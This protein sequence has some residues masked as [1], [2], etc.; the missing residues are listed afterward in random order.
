MAI[1]LRL[2]GNTLIVPV[3]VTPKGSR[4]E[5]LPFKDGD[6]WVKVKVTAP[7][8][9]GAATTAML[10]LLARQLAIPASRLRI[11]SG[12]QARQKQVGLACQNPEAT[13][14]LKIR[15]AHCLQSD[16]ATCFTQ[17]GAS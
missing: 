5:I 7:P 6:V 17:G 3:K 9:D 15:L 4:N 12:H 8:D 2:Q 10:S 16:V 11:I 1:Q 14:L 13:D